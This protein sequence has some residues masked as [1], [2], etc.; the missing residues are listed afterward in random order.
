MQDNLARDAADLC[1]RG[2]LSECPACPETEKEKAIY[3][4]P[5]HTIIN[6]QRRWAEAQPK[7][8]KHN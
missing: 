5:E 1:G 3:N 8:E 6:P 7:Y 2:E 4:G